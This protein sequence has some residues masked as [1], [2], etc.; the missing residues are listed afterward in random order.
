MAFRALLFSKNAETNAALETACESTGIRVEVCSDIFTAIEKG[1]TRAF[2][3]VIA[4]W[5][6]QPEASFLLKRARESAPNRQTVAIAVVDRDPTPAELRDNRLDFLVFRPISAEE[7]DAV[8]EKALEQMQPLSAKDAEESSR[9]ADASSEGPITA[10][11]SADAPEQV[12]QDPPAGYPEA[13]AA[14]GNGQIASDTYQEEPQ[15]RSHRPVFRGACAALLVLAAAFFLWRSRQGIEYL[16]QTPEGMYRVLRESVA[17][18]FYQNQTGALPVGS[19]G[20]DAQQDA[21]FSRN[22]S[23]NAKPPA[24]GV[25]ATES[26]MTE[27]RMPLPKAPDLPL[28]VPVFAHQDPAPIRVERAA[29]PESM[30]NSPPI[31]PPLVVAVSPAQM[32]PV[33]APQPPPAI[34]QI[35]EPV[36][37]SEEAARALLVHS[38]DPVYPPEALAQKLHGPV[39]LQARVGR[40]GTVEDLKIVRGYFILGRAAIAAVKQWRFQPYT[41]NGHAAATQTVLTINFSYPP[42]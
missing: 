3:C 22:P 37:V 21:Y 41:V 1:K 29:I 23:P 4:D 24:L 13:D 2:S 20:S 11:D 42:G 12:P 19:A 5:A 38:V 18:L 36:A 33:S 6:D 7:A 31:A 28:P 10:A 26:T 35:S 30:R 34:Q 39:I 15:G 8:L 16:S 17:A 40:D 27:A 14:D 9:Q 32:M 25:V